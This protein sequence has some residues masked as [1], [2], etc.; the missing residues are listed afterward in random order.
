M[1]SKYRNLSRYNSILPYISRDGPDS[2]SRLIL[3]FRL[4]LKQ[5]KTASIHSDLFSQTGCRQLT[6]QRQKL[7]FCCSSRTGRSTIEKCFSKGQMDSV[8]SHPDYNS[9]WSNFALLF[10]LNVSHKPF[11]VFFL[12]FFSPES[13]I[14]MVSPTRSAWSSDQSFS[15]MQCSLSWPLWK[16]WLS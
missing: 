1:G 2:C 16:Q 6:S 9:A 4:T 10:F 5:K 15:V 7:L 11:V 8:L 12:V 13:S 3:C 14:R